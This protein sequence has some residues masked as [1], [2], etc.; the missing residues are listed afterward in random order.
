MFILYIF[1][2][3]ELYQ[4]VYD[5]LFIFYRKVC[6]IVIHIGGINNFSSIQWATK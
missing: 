3:W 5:V 2:V 1:Q 4:A 6:F